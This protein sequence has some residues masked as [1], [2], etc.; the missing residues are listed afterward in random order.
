MTIVSEC[1]M[2]SDPKPSNNLDKNITEIAKM[3]ARI[4]ILNKV[5][6][7]TSFSLLPCYFVHSKILN[8]E[9]LVRMF[10]MRLVSNS[11][12]SPLKEA[13]QRKTDC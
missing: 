13:K 5:P 2:I 9:K 12:K 6:Q 4:A 10:R 1:E 3:H 7:N 8:N 11:P